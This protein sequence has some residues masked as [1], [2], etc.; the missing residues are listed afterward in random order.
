[1]SDNL[2]FPAFAEKIRAK[3]KYASDGSDLE[4][5]RV[6]GDNLEKRPSFSPEAAHTSAAT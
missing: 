6:E 4:G 2:T 5:E 1:M 3:S